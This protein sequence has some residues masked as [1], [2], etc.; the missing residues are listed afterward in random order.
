MI[1]DQIAKTEP[2]PEPLIK[3]RFAVYELDTGDALLAYQPD[4]VDEVGNQVIPG[5]LWRLVQSALKGEPI[6]VNP[7]EL[8]TVLMGS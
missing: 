7:I 5:P 3:G 4:G 6:D 2:A 1:D 8:M